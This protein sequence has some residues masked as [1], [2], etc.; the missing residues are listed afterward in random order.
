[1]G[2][3]WGM[4]HYSRLELAVYNESKQAKVQKQ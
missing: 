2:D 4:K 3:G 1:M